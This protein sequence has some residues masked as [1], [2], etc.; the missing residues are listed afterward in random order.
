[1]T[2]KNDEKA[3]FLQ[4]LFKNLEN[5]RNQ[6]PKILDINQNLISPEY[7]EI[8]QSL[9]SYFKNFIAKV[10]TKEQK[11]GKLAMRKANSARSMG[12]KIEKTRKKKE[13]A[14]R[15]LVLKE[16]AQGVLVLEGKIMSKKNIKATK[17]EDNIIS[18]LNK[19]SIQ[20]TKKSYKFDENLSKAYIK[21]DK[22]KESYFSN[23]YFD[24]AGTLFPVE[25]FET[26]VDV[27]SMKLTK[28][29]E[30]LFKDDSNSKAKKS[31]F[32][33]DS[34]SKAKKS[35]SKDNSN[36]NEEKPSS[37]DSS[38]S[39]SE[40]PKDKDKDK[41]DDGEEEE[42]EEKEKEKKKKKK[43]EYTRGLSAQKIS[44]CNKSC[45]F[46]A[47]CN[48]CDGK[49]GFGTYSCVD[50]FDEGRCVRVVKINDKYQKT[51][52]KVIAEKQ[53]LYNTSENEEPSEKEELS[54]EEKE[55][56][57]TWTD[58]RKFQESIIGQF[59]TIYDLYS[60]VEKPVQGKKEPKP[61]F[62]KN[63]PRERE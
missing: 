48:G 27:F 31:L 8:F 25:I 11:I 49:D 12:K 57:I 52:M 14:K 22:A 58:L 59:R 29:V 2:K 20:A 41:D 39:D 55:K 6:D 43:K 10:S 33:D 16:D 51:V 24:L 9:R 32:K 38:S 47:D 44:D 15:D 50:S 23:Y 5:L 26:F 35:L 36:S 28:A 21:V 46:T 53:K 45:R 61:I 17:K 4:N 13:D 56:K 3:I 37:N 19:Q 30:S 42:E 40:E 63:M 18:K 62:K 34:N 7:Y 60:G 1:M 54:P